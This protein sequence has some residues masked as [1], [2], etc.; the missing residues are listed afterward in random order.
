[1]R[2]TLS[3]KNFCPFLKT[4][5]SMGGPITDLATEKQDL[6]GQMEQAEADAKRLAQRRK[7]EIDPEEYQLFL[8][9]YQKLGP[10]SPDCDRRHG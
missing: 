1:M 2:T 10:G 7:S 6:Q 3:S 4:G 8:S 5:V 9:A